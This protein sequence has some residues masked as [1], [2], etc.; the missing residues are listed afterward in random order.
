MINAHIED[1]VALTKFLYWIKNIK[2]LNLTEQ[3]VEKKLENY[4]D[5]L[6]LGIDNS[7]PISAIHGHGINNLKVAIENFIKTKIRTH[8]IIEVTDEIV[9][10]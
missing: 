9:P 7:F 1:G 6:S 3:Q 2:K 4:W 8:P 5:S 10:K